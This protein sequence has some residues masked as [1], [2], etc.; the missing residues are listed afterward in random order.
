MRKHDKR[1]LARFW[2][3]I[4]L[5]FASLVAIDGI[6]SAQTTF[7]LGTNMAQDTL[8]GAI[9]ASVVSLDVD[10]AADFPATGTFMIRLESE[11]MKVTGVSSLTFTVVRAQGGTIATSHS[12]GESVYLVIEWGYISEIQDAVNTVETRVPNAH[13]LGGSSHS[14]ATDTTPAAAHL[15]LRNVGNTAYENQAMSGDATITAAGVVDLAAGSVDDAEIGTV[16]LDTLDDVNAPTP[17]DN[18]SLTWDNGTSKWIPE[19]VV[20]SAPAFDGL[21][22]VTVA[23]PSGGAIAL[24]DGVSLWQDYL[25]SGD[26]ALSNA[27][28]FALADG[29]V[30]GG[31]GGVITDQTVTA[32]D[33]APS[34]VFSNEIADNEVADVDLD[35]SD[36]FTMNSLITSAG[37]TNLSGTMFTGVSDTT[38]GVYIGYAQAATW[39]PIT[40]WENAADSNTLTNYWQWNLQLGDI[41]L[42][43]VGGTR[44]SRVILTI[45]DDTGDFSV[46]YGL[47]TNDFT[48]DGDLLVSQSISSETR[49]DINTEYAP[50]ATTVLDLGGLRTG[51]GADIVRIDFTNHGAGGDGTADAQILF[52]KDSAS[53]NSG[54]LDFKTRVD[55]GSGLVSALKLDGSQNATFGADVS[56]TGAFLPRQVTDA[57][58]MT[59]TGGTQSEIVWNTSNSTLYVCTVT[60]GSA[61]TWAALH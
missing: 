27:G 37:F 35:N 61:A 55:L 60:H 11:I 8:N 10:S 33:L 15:Y 17:N 30:S 43:T 59:A 24:W 40:R 21:S 7:M 53:A 3:L 31:L 41:V 42:N 29:S 57:G 38:R 5:V 46:T 1:F 9:D 18:D 6:V 25:M 52:E 4:F 16:D 34:S 26:G 2:G 39:G 56:V 28:V 45:D 22:D 13:A 58:P 14:D 36:D 20:T 47:I 12:D 50:G 54:S 49:V 19:A 23:T 44:G 48:M 32:D 51:S